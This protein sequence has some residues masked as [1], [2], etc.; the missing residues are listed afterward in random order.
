MARFDL[1]EVRSTGGLAVDVQADLLDHLSTRLVIPLLR[2]PEAAWG[3]P[4]LAPQIEVDSTLYTLGTPFMIGVP[5]KE[6][7]GPVGTLS[8]YEYQISEAVDVL[9]SGV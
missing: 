1:Y 2:G 7:N 9:L 5:L 8:K 6:L 3:I 4:R